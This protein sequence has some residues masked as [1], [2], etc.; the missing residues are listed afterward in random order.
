MFNFFY[1]AMGGFILNSDRGKKEKI[2][3]EATHKHSKIS[4][5]NSSPRVD[6]YIDFTRYRFSQV[7]LDASVVRAKYSMGTSPDDKDIESV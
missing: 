3:G 7:S 2:K 5:R 4:K 6:F 1:P